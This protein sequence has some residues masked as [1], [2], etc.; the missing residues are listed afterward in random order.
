LLLLLATAIIKSIDRLT[1]EDRV[2]VLI[3]DDTLYDR[4]RSKK[5]ELL[6]RVFDHTTHKFVKGFKML[7]LGW[8]D[9]NTF[10]PVAFSLLTS[11]PGKKI[12]HPMDEQIDKRSCGYQKR[13]EAIAKSTETR[14]STGNEITSAIRSLVFILL[15][16]PINFIWPYSANKDTFPFNSKRL[17]FFGS[18]NIEW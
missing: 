1:S 4:S 14:N 3:V 9:G 7:T 12:L 10:L 6:S 2:N 8:S 15:L 18:W 17:L 16:P 11:R 5:V 13:T